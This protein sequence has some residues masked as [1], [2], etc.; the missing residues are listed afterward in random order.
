[1]NRARKIL[2]QALL[3]VVA[4]LVFGAFAT[5]SAYAN[6]EFSETGISLKDANGDFTRKAGA[7]PDFSFRFSVPEIE[8]IRDGELV[9]GPAEG[10]RD[11]ILDLPPGLVGNPVPFPTCSME[12]LVGVS[13]GNNQLCPVDSQI[14]VGKIDLLVG[15]YEV[16]LFNLEHGPEVPARFGLDIL[17]A[18]AT[19]TPEVRPGDY[20][21]TAGSMEISQ[22]IPLIGASLTFWG[23]PSSSAHDT[24]RQGT[25]L[26][27]VLGIPF[28][29]HAPKV[30]FFGNPTACS[31]GAQSFTVRGDSWEHPGIFDELSLT[32]DE[33]GTP[34][35]WE[36]CENLPFAPTVELALRSHDAHAPAGL[37]VHV[38]LPQN[39]TVD[40]VSTS[41]AKQVALTLPEGMAISPSTASGQSGCTEAQ[42]GLGSNDPPAC[43]ASSGI[44][45]IDLE[46]PLLN[47]VLH[48][49]LVLAAQGDNPFGATYA[50]YML[51]KGPGFYLK[52][53]GQLL[54]DKQTGQLRT[55]FS[56]LP[57]LPFESVDV[58][59]NGGS[60]APLST[61]QNCGTYTARSEITPW[62]RPNDPV[63]QDLPI[64]IDQNCAGGG[65]SPTLKGGAASPVA[66]KRSPFGLRITRQDGE[67]NVSRIDVT[68]P[69]GQLA[70]LK[71]VAE[72]P[73]AQAPNGDCPAN[74]QIGVAGAAIGVG[75]SPLQVPQPGKAPTAL[76]LGGPY[77]GAPLSLVALVPAQAGPF[78][79]G[80]VVVRT[81]LNVDPT[82]A[83]VS[84]KSDPLPQIIEGVP[85]QYRDIRIE[86]TRPDFGV[87]PTS[88]ERMAITSTLTS[89]TGTE[90]YP[91]A[92]YQVAECAALG[93]SPS[94][95][96][97]L[98]GGTKRTAH[99]AVSAT[100]KAPAGQANIA[101][102]TVILPQ[103]E[104][105]DNA[106][107]NNPC[108]LVQFRQGACPKGSIL[109]TATAYTPLLDK[110]LT[111]PVYFRS[112]GGERELPDLVADLDGQIH[113]TLVGFI[114]SVKTGGETSRVRT[115]FM[116]VPDAPVSKFQIHLFGGKKGLVQNSRNLCS[117]T[118]KAK[119]Q[120]TGQNGKRHDF[121]AKI[122]T[123]CG[124]K[125]GSR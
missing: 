92:A 113:V 22:G 94:L 17:G 97:A 10:P 84:A 96:L 78:D 83:Q 121:A 46:T 1:M 64:Q 114:D 30:P 85:L 90:A 74:S 91:S 71:G 34:F 111:G 13:N 70:S 8:K 53:P 124:G 25:G 6:F 88:C 5:P 100:L 103:S 15:S 110:P 76:F 55:V 33:Q 68:L 37:G 65:F 35:V 3:A 79:L 45:T 32:A 24:Q 69:E 54:V 58:E 62:A 48:G 63:V 44:G 89:A 98:K 50:V 36:G 86:L 20:G 11:V 31:G 115:R 51:I 39:E 73:E 125:K 104:F 57:Q 99:P 118:P 93:F 43:P 49:E 27:F 101:K 2:R 21:I 7:H 66:G 108:T 47:E 122:A 16:G 42:V 95:K 120:M 123:T 12:Q 102:T 75:S 112:N 23:N 4:S 60:L 117:F 41:A 56:D 40:G 80:N 82:T 67:Q 72:C 52:L 87:N 106:H 109:G 61:P 105:I 116:N 9:T 18:V 38:G 26:P 81:A 59:L 28:E 107:I 119:V 14:G 29:S 19:I 77:K